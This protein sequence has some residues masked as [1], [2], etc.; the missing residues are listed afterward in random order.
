MNPTAM[1]KKASAYERTRATPASS[2]TTGWAGGRAGSGGSRVPGAGAAG[3][4]GAEAET[5]SDAC[6]TGTRVPGDN[7]EGLRLPRAGGVSI[8]LIALLTE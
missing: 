5:E 4:I 7:G 3:R 2:A 8:P 1:T 6:G